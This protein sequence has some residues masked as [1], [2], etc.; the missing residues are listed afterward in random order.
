MGQ[1]GG[2]PIINIVTVYSIQTVYTLYL[3]PNTARKTKF[4]DYTLRCRND[5]KI[6]VCESTTRVLEAVRYDVIPATALVF[7]ND[8]EGMLPRLKIHIETNEGV[9]L[10]PIIVKEPFTV[11]KV[12]YLLVLPRGTT[13]VKNVHITVDGDEIIVPNDLTFD[14]MEAPYNYENYL[15]THLQNMIT[16]LATQMFNQ[17]KHLDSEIASLGR[18]VTALENKAGG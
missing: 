6:P 10:E 16:S 13:G 1:A 7:E 9:T 17:V 12:A 15:F 11:Y 2:S 5:I 18:R 8:I 4:I 14:V 3:D